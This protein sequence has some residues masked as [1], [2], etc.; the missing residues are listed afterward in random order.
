MQLEAIL[1]VANMTANRIV[2]AFISF[3]RRLGSFLRE[4]KAYQESGPKARNQI[5]NRPARAVLRRKKSLEDW[6]RHEGA[7]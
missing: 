4:Q 1:N 6:R 3:P 5:D 2:V 7:D